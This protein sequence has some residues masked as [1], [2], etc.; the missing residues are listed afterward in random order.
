MST[1]AHGKKLSPRSRVI[2]PTAFAAIAAVEGL[3][4]N[5]ASRARLN[6]LKASGLSPDARRTEVLRAYRS[7][8]R[9][10]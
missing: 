9:A 4:L 7:L 8:S 1:G 5:T 3:K 10:K 2:G 6:K